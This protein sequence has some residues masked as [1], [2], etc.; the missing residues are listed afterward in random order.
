MLTF[1]IM[2]DDK[3]DEEDAVT[4]TERKRV[5]TVKGLEEKLHFKI[6]ARRSKLRQLTAKSNEI[7]LLMENACNLLEVE[8]IQFRIYKRMFEEFVEINGS[9]LMQIRISGFNLKY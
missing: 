1:H 3:E 4:L 8:N 7:D 9:V 6:N 2:A 5:P